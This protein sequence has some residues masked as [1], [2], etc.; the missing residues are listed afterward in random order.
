VASSPDH[1]RVLDVPRFAQPDDTSCGPT[2][3]SQVMAFYGEATDVA[4]LS[5]RVQRNPDGG[6]QAVHLAGLALEL[7]YDVRLYPFGVQVFD[8]TWWDLGADALEGRLEARAHRLRVD[9]AA[10]HLVDEVLAWQGCLRAGARVD[11]REPNPSL[12]VSILDRGHPII[13]GL[14]ATWLYREA[15]CR[16]D[17]NEDDDIGG[18]PVGHFV[19]VRGYTGRGKHFHI[20][21]PSDEAAPHLHPAGAARGTYPL[22]ADRLTHAILLGDSTR[23]AVVVEIWPGRRAAA[24][25]C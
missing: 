3:L 6:T 19:V 9:G 12:L 4:H 20:L 17:D 22:P 15:R 25:T 24:R 21:D 2:C 18:W 5:S 1:R 10:P 16:P 14:N 8:P 23:D 7:G 11:F 13:A